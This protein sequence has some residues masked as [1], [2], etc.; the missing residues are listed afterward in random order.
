MT[1]KNKN[2]MLIGGLL[3]LFLVAYQFSFS[4]TIIVRRS[5][6]KLEQQ[7]AIF[8]STPVQLAKLKQREKQ[9]DVILAA[10]NV[11][12]NSL[13]N[14]ILK[15]LNEL[16]IE[17]KFKIIKFEEPHVYQ[18]PATQKTTTYDITLEG[19]FEALLKVIYALEQKYSFGNVVQMQFEKK[20]NF[21]TNREYL[22]CRLLLQR[23]N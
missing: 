1:Q 10:N 11:K 5:V 20:K 2:R 18:T 4:K 7:T 12:G 9:L 17:D 15:T 21:R 3:V 16:S 6:K 13:Q 19:D 8:K 14:N 23:L 22:Q